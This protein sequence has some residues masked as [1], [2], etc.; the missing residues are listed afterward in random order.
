MTEL[1]LSAPRT[2]RAR[3]VRASGCSEDGAQVR[4]TPWVSVLMPVTVCAHGELGD[5]GAGA[6]EEGGVPLDAADE[7]ED[8]VA[9]RVA[10]LEAGLIGAFDVHL[11]EGVDGDL[12]EEVAGERE[13]GVRARAVMPPPQ[14]FSRGKA[15][16]FSS[17]RT[18]RPASPSLAAAVEPAGPAPTMATSKSVGEAES[19][20]AGS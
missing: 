9:L 4:V 16:A 6:A 15:L 3:K 14:G 2:A 10:V 12:A 7:V 8:G 13:G 19:G 11:R 20:T 17:R 1:A 5:A 18:R